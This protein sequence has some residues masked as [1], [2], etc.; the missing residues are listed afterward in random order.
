MAFRT[1]CLLPPTMAEAISLAKQLNDMQA[2][3][4][5]FQLFRVPRHY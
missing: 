4:R 5:V 2:S 1:D 3:G